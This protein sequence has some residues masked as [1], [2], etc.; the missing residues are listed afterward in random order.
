MIRVLFVCLG[1]ICRSPTAHA[2]FEHCVERQGLKD[3]IQ[4]DS[5][6]TAGWHEG[7]APDARSQEHAR[8]RGYAMGHLRARQ[9]RHRD[10]AEF[11]LV[12]AMDGSN[13]QNLLDIC[14]PEHGHK[15]RLFLEFAAHADVLEVPDP[16]YGGEEG[17]ERVLDLVEDASQ[18]L[19]R[20]LRERLKLD[21][22]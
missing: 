9:V 2:V 5:A 18:G 6:G 10:F 7:K 14:P 8:R 1:N 12:L 20:H 3:H 16:Y 22:L 19:L 17:F 4:V 13:R 11:D 21:R 15:I